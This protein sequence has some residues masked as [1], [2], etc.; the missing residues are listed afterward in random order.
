MIVLKKH[1]PS[2]NVYEQVA[3]LRILGMVVENEEYAKSV[4]NNISYFRLIK[5]FSL[6]LKVKNRKYY[7]NIYFEDVVNLYFFNSAFRQKIFLQ[8]EKVEVS[9]RCRLANYFCNRYGVLAYENKD[10]FVD[11]MYYYELL[12]DINIEVTRNKKTPFVKNFTLNYEDGKIP[13]YALVELLSF[14]TLSKFYKNMKNEDKKAISAMY[15]IGYTYFESWIETLSYI[16]NICA[17]Y[18]RFYNTNLSKTPKL[19]KQYTEKG[20]NNFYVF[21]ILLVLKHILPN[22]CNWNSFIQEIE[23]LIYE[24]KNINLYSMGFPENWTEYLYNEKDAALSTI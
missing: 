12:D 1:Q 21:A 10:N 2:M 17:H 4:L 24:Y 11:T 14:G 3:N 19:Y 15:G 18:G 7:N 5:A 16:R 6:G 8:I 20:I 23:L 22:D 9:L 13:L